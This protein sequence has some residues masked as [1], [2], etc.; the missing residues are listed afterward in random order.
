M[1]FT[2]QIYLQELVF[3]SI[4]LI[5][6]KEPPSTSSGSEGATIF[7]SLQQTFKKVPLPEQLSVSK[8]AFS[9]NR[10][11]QSPN[12]TTCNSTGWNEIESS[13]T[14]RNQLLSKSIVEFNRCKHRNCLY[15]WVIWSSR[16]LA[17]I[18]QNLDQAQKKVGNYEI[19]A[20]E[21]KAIYQAFSMLHL[22]SS[23]TTQE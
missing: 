18:N 21:G 23:F 7:V 3:L 22:F 12:V 19:S 8:G 1:L 17:V 6:I 16:S 20:I 4:D 9:I 11:T 14:R 13:D 15:L 10:V 2:V 5:L